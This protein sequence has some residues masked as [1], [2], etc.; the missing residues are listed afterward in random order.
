MAVYNKIYRLSIGG[1]ICRAA[2]SSLKIFQYIPTRARDFSM[3]RKYDSFR[4]A[5]WIASGEKKFSSNNRNFSFPLIYDLT[6]PIFTVA[7]ISTCI[8]L[9]YFSLFLPFFF[10]YLFRAVKKKEFNTKTFLREKFILIFLN[11]W[12]N[13]ASRDWR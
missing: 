6:S 9:I 10:N 11:L 13:W 5:K 8:K 4:P 2:S 1:Y 7:T 12:N 3:V